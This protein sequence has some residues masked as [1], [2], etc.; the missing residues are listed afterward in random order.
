MQGSFC[1]DFILRVGRVDVTVHY[2]ANRVCWEGGGQRFCY[3]SDMVIEFRNFINSMIGAPV[4]EIVNE[5][6]T[7]FAIRR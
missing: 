3:S 5:F 7:Y 6:Q 1:Q 4:T 2:Y